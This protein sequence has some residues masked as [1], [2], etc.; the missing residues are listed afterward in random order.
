MMSDQGKHL[1]RLLAFSTA[2]GALCAGTAVLADPAAP[3]A[4]APTQTE[5]TQQ[6]QGSGGDTSNQG[7]GSAN[8]GD[9]QEIVIT[10][11][12]RQ[13]LLSQ[14]SQSISVVGQD[15]LER[16]LA[17]SLPDYQALVP[18]LAIQQSTPG[19]ARIILRGVNTGSVGSTVAVYIDDT[20][21]GSSSSLVRHCAT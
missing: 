1:R 6:G 11:L 18:G 14:A 7:Q 15:T 16:E 5:G 19:E 8:S 13:E 3:A 10:G 4:A 12:K 20:P 21:F 17:V 2:I 9:D